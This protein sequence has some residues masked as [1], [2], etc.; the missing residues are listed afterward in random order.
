[1]SIDKIHQ[2]VNSLAKTAEND[3]KLATPFLASKLTKYAS[4]YPQDKTLGGMA[5]VLN[6]MVRNKTYF[7]RRADFKSLGH[8]LQTN[9][10]KF[11]ELFQEELGET[12]AEPTVTT[13]DRDESIKSNPY[14]IG[15]QV[16]ANALESVFD[17]HLS[18]KMYSQPIANLAMK[19]VGSTLDSWNLRPA[20][21][22]VSDGND[23]F[24][25][26]KADYET[27]KGVTSFYVPVEVTKNKVTD[28]EVFMGN[29]GPEDLNHTN[30][31]AYVTRQAGVKTKIGGTD[32]LNA[33]N[34]AASDKREVTAAELAVTR[35]NATRQGKSEF[36]QDQIVGLHVE[37]AP[38]QDVALPKYETFAS[39]EEQWSSPSGQACWHFGAELVSSGRVHVT[40]ELQSF[41]F[42]NPQ[43]VVTKSDDNTIFYG[44]S[45]D[46]GKV[47]FTVPVKIV[48]NKL[49]KPTVLLCNGAL[50]TFDR[51]G[52]NELVSENKTDIKVA[53]VASTMATLKPSE[54]LT[55]LRQA[56]NDGNHAKAEDALN[57]L[58]NAGDKKAY[59]TAFQIYM[60]GLSSKKVAETK[61]SKMVK[62][63]KNAVSEYPICSHTGLPINKVYQDKDGNCRP[64]FRKGMDETYEGTS[65]INAKIFG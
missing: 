51:S 20:Q 42:T 36:F 43:V 8:K 32:I 15:D 55:N 30:I 46:T 4:S 49:T 25:V 22:T 45:L 6:D 52:I 16:L 56:M 23:K 62:S 10:T 59:D 11:A 33:L 61:C 27:P 2:L 24:I 17:K 60:E 47:A 26:I 3:Q 63:A 64:L 28:P 39:F 53:S 29:T 14:H 57:V 40:R 50:T 65:F 31:K 5:R 19:S 58:A 38:K 9:N 34:L 13:Y 18:L 41:G 12:P 35:L 21:L 7:I 37:A 48:A 44:V 54:V 1:M